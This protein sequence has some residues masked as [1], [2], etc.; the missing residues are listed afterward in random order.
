V[1]PSPEAGSDGSYTYSL[2]NVAGITGPTASFLNM[3]VQPACRLMTN[4]N[5]ALGVGLANIALAIDT[6]GQSQA[7]EDVASQG[8]V[9][10]VNAFVKYLVDQTLAAESS[11]EGASLG[12]TIVVD[13]S[14]LSRGMEALKLVGGNVLKQGAKIGVM[15]F[16]ADTLVSERAGQQNSGLNQGQSLIDQAD[17]GANIEANEVERTQLFGRPL[18]P[19]EVNDQVQNASQL[20]AK[21]NSSK[22]LYDRYFALSNPSSLLSNL[23]LTLGNYMHPK[24]LF[25]AFF[26]LCADLLHPVSLFSAIVSFSGGKAHADPQ[27]SSQVYGNVQFGWTK[28][29]KALINSNNSYYPLE[30][31]KILRQSGKE[32]AIAS[33]YAPCFGYTYNSSGNGDMDPT[34]PNGDLNPASAGLDPGSLAT[35]ITTGEIPRD[36]SGNVEET[37]GLCSPQNLGINNPSYGDLVFRWR[38]AMNYDTT[39]QSL[40]NLQTL[41]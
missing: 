18:T 38:L 1:S 40:T 19:S 20:V 30:N 28:S 37:G 31:E 29:E 27:P 15:T 12:A 34:D 22:S 17:S 25:G 11:G 21:A 33:T 9:K 23:G 14:S 3:V 32:A 13:G 5:V 4:P 35:L 36:G 41:N 7:Y 10:V 39:L 6:F 16:L 24:I 26:K 2:F 8:A